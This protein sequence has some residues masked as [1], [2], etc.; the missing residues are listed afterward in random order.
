MKT[1]IVVVRPNPAAGSASL[2]LAAEDELSFVFTGDWEN[3][4]PRESKYRDRVKQFGAAVR[5]RRHSIPCWRWRPRQSKDRPE[6]K[7]RMKR[8]RISGRLGSALIIVALLMGCGGGE[9]K[10]L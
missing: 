3:G 4:H 1:E 10:Q 8:S 7:A 5:R 2:E 6:R 9:V